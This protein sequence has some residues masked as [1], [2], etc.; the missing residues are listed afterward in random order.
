MRDKI[1]T[2]ERGST[3][4]VRGTAVSIRQEVSSSPGCIQFAKIERVVSFHL[5]DIISLTSL[6]SILKE[7]GGF[8]KPRPGICPKSGVVIE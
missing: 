2:G 8:V 7:H 3:D 4:I 6:G 1:S 5:L